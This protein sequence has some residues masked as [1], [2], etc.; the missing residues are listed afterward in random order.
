MNDELFDC[1]RLKNHRAYGHK[2]YTLPAEIAV[3]F[4]TPLRVMLWLSERDVQLAHYVQKTLMQ[5]FR[6]S[7]LAMYLQNES[8]K[9][10]RLY[11]ML[12]DSKRNVLCLCIKENECGNLIWL[13]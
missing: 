4:L 6:S 12:E 11:E 8:K 10:G 5:R 2:S 1:S 3:P 7:V 9:T 13:Y